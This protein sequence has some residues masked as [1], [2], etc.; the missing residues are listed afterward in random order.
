MHPNRAFRRPA[1]TDNL[2]FA[3]DRGFGVL[4][5]AGMDG[6]LASHIP[7]VLNKDGAALDAHIV[8]SN[9]ICSRL[10][11]AGNGGVSA[12]LAVSGPDAYISPDWYGIEDQVPTWN[13]V[14]VHLFGSV[15]LLPEEKLRS[16]LNDLSSFFERRLA[17]KPAWT[18]DKVT[19]DTYKRLSRMIVPVRMRIERVEGT[20]KFSQNKPD[21]AR[22]AAAAALPEYG[23]GMAVDAL[24]SLM[25][26]VAE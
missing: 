3:R 11:E 21:A 1:T 7:F 20:W 15:R 9:P 2:A 12:L 10:G 18:L 4:T 23:P 19:P 14:A 22:L 24:K 17:P 16:H 8:R 6:P 26:S 13:Y 5:L 25:R